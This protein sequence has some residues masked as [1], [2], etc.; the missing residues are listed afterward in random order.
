MTNPLHALKF[1]EQSPEM[2]WLP[3]TAS[4]CI[5]WSQES[6]VSGTFKVA[7]ER[8][9]FLQLSNHEGRF[10]Y[11]IGMLPEGDEPYDEFPDDAA[12]RSWVM[13]YLRNR[14]LRNV[15]INDR[16]M[17]PAY[18]YGNRS[19]YNANLAPEVTDPPVKAK[20]DP[21]VFTGS[22]RDLFPPW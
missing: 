16:S 10:H 3:D 12:M 13:E 19:N 21:T 5:S 9:I 20:Y 17:Y 1:S 14:E 7:G 2:P 22:M 4:D 8:F 6:G 11:W 18:L 15:I